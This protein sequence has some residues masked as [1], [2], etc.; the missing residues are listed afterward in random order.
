[1]T[2]IRTAVVGAGKMGGIHAKTY[3][4]MADCELVA[5]VDVDENRAGRL[6]EKYGC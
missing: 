5:I 4:E 2:Q 1:M 6:G 3:N